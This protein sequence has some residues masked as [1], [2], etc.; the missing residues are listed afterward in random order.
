ML[1]RARKLIAEVRRGS[2]PTTEIIRTSP[3][4][5]KGFIDTDKSQNTEEINKIKKQGNLDLEK[6]GNI[7]PKS[8][9]KILLEYPEKLINSK[10]KSPDRIGDEVIMII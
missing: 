3:E 2:T 4:S 6:N 9:K 8:P 7:T 10:E 1:E 5:L